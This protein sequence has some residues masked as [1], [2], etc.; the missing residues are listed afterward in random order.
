MFTGSMEENLE[1]A[2]REE[3]A[4]RYCRLGSQSLFMSQSQNPSQTMDLNLSIVAGADGTQVEKSQIG[5]QLDQNGP[6]GASLLKSSQ[7][8][9]KK[10]RKGRKSGLGFG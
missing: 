6:L 9:R 3:K 10:K 2:E 7:K 4:E 8:P 1:E 5:S